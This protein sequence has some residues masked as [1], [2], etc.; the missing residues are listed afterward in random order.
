MR[1]LFILTKK[2]LLSH[3][4]RIVIEE[5]RNIDEKHNID[6]RLLTR[7]AFWCAQLC[8]PQ[9]EQKIAIQFKSSRILNTSRLL[10]YISCFFFFL[11]FY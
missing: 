10:N 8:T 5:I 4:E 9:R 7:E 11:S 2:H 1:L 6:E 3:F